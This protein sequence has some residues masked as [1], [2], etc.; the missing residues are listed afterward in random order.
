M[1]RY[2]VAPRSS[3][4]DDRGVHAMQ[5]SFDDLV[6]RA[7]IE[8]AP[9]ECDNLSSTDLFAV[10]KRAEPAF[11][12]RKYGVPDWMML[13]RNCKYMQAW[14]GRLNFIRVRD[15]VR[16]GITVDL[17]EYS[18]QAGPKESTPGIRRPP[19][20]LANRALHWK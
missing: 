20:R 4:V 19:R 10:I 16:P 12:A 14:H 3:D 11:A 7:I 6:K 5:H 8:F 9:V 15:A 2:S 17:E 1:S 18:Y 13:L